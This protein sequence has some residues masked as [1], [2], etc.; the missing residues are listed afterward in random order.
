[1]VESEATLT[2]A[3]KTRY[4]VDV[5]SAADGDD[6]DGELS[7]YYIE[8]RSELAEVGGSTRMSYGT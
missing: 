3:A 7:I 2:M 8:A 5:G 1:V 4:V 6:F